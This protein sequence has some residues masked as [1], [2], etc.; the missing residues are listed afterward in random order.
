MYYSQAI[1][2]ATAICD[3]SRRVEK[4]AR[5]RFRKSSYPAIRRLDCVCDGHRLV[6]RGKVASYFHKQLA[7]ESLADLRRDLEIVNETVVEK[8]R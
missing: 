1:E 7:Q 2:N 3:P 5:E 4:L 6:I 8:P